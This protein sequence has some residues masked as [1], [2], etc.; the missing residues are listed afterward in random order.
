MRKK[1]RTKGRSDNMEE[2]EELTIMS[3]KV[4]LC[5]DCVKEIKRQE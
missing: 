2:M 3:A 1:K 4:R 5:K